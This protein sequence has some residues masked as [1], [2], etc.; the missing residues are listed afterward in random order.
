MGSFPTIFANFTK[1]KYG[2]V[3]N[4]QKFEYFNDYFRH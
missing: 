3:G 1:Y 4:I 2:D